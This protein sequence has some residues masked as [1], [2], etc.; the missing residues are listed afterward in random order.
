M[1]ILK[2]RHEHFFLDFMKPWIKVEGTDNNFVHYKQNF[3]WGNVK[4]FYIS[5]DLCTSIYEGGP[6][7]LRESLEQAMKIMSIKIF[8]DLT[9][10]RWGEPER[11]MDCKNFIETNFKF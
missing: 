9:R 7:C 1:R 3:K 6:M 5:F 11:L 2:M 8:R 10:E 4:P